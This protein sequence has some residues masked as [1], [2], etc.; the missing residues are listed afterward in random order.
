M[1]MIPTNA[2]LAASLA[3][4]AAYEAV[5]SS[6]ELADLEDTARVAWEVLGDYYERDPSALGP[7]PVDH[8]ASVVRLGEKNPKKVERAV[9]YL[10]GLR[11][12]P[13]SAPNIRALLEAAARVRVGDKLAQALAMRRERGEIEGLIDAYRE[14]D[15]VYGPESETGTDWD[16]LVGKRADPAALVKVSPPCLNRRLGGGVLPGHGITIYARPEA[17]KTALALTMATGFAR[18]GSRVLYAGNED[19]VTDLA[20]RAV[21]ILS[22]RTVAEVDENPSE[23]VAIARAK[24]GDRLVFRDLV[25]STLGELERLVRVHTPHVLIVDQ[26]RNLRVGA[27]ADNFTQLL[28]RVAQGVRNLGKKYGMVTV[29]VTQAGDSARGKA[30]LDDGDVDSSNTGIP[31]AADILLGIGVTETLEKASMRMLSLAKNKRTG[32]H[33]HWTVALDARTSRVRTLNEVVPT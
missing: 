23:A 28:D 19:P 29:S 24:G 18:R 27:G 21:A 26:L 8:A 2:L 11:D 17:G 10:E 6:G 14:I 33:D 30:I 12:L 3:S 4:R 31:G 22:N 13:V 16:A 25:P 15:L 9:A 7:V 5:K 32:R 1:S 20:A